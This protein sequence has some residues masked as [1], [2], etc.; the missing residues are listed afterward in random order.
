M[1][2]NLK[3]LI[4]V[5]EVTLEE[6]DAPNRLSTCGTRLCER[7]DLAIHM[8]YLGVPEM[9]TIILLDAREQLLQHWLHQK[10]FNRRMADPRAEPGDLGQELSR[11]PA[12][13]RTLIT[14]RYR[15]TTQQNA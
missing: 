14:D 15:G 11:L 7:M 10:A 2:G 6:C 8:A 12:H 4:H 3:R 5:L 1:D 9:A 13:V